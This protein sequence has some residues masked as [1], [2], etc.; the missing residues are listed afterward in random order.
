[1]S[2]DEDDRIRFLFRQVYVA[3]S[4][5]TT[6]HGNLASTTYLVLTLFSFQVSQAF[7]TIPDQ[8]INAA[9]L[10][11]H[12]RIINAFLN[13]PDVQAI[14]FRNINGTLNV[15]NT[16]SRSSF[17]D[18]VFYVI[19]LQRIKLSRD[20]IREEVIYGDISAQPIDHLAC[21]TDMILE[22]SISNKITSVPVCY[23][24]KKDIVDNFDSFKSNIQIIQGHIRG[25]TCLP[26]PN[27]VDPDCNRAAGT[28]EVTHQSNQHN[29]IH[30]LESSIILWTKQVCP[31]ISPISP[32]LCTVFG[33]QI[34]FID[35][36]HNH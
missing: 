19:K 28:E 9:L 17:S 26:L 20:K 29:R 8:K 35:Q 21:L 14:F 6:L 13:K 10:M 23:T 11:D 5:V 24:I 33:R 30:N 2:S 7:R 36:N 32:L 27:T 4:M 16:S 25:R 22:S 18:T 3:Y 12:S 1:M 34:Y 15:S 31:S